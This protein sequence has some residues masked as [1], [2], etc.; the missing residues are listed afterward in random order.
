MSLK[1]GWYTIRLVSVEHPD[2]GVGGEY[3][4]LLPDG[5]V[6]VEPLG[7]VTPPEARRWHVETVNGDRNIYKIVKASLVPEGLREGL[8]EDTSEV[9]V[10]FGPDPEE[11]QISNAGVGHNVYLISP[12]KKFPIGVEHLVGTDGNRVVVKVFPVNPGIDRPA[13]QFKLD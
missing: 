2:P 13:W 11:W 6:R 5:Q 10:V 1:A 12:N 9:P 8:L 7:P 3:I 4:T